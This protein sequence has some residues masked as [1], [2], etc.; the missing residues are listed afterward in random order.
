[1]IKID[2]GMPMP[3]SKSEKKYP[4]REM[5]IGDSFFE[6]EVNRRL[7]A[8]YASELGKKIGMK[9]SIRRVDGGIR[10]WRTA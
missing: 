2:K 6:E 3:K 7:L 9:F 4:F 10:V 1:M 8:S 5:E